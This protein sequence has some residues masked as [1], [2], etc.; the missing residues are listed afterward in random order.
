[1][2]VKEMLQKAQEEKYAIGAF[3]TINIEVTQAILAAADELRSPVII[4]VTEKTMDY[5]GGRNIYHTIKNLAEF[6]YPHVP[7][8]IHLDHGKSFEVVQRAVEVGIQSVMYDGS[9]KNYEDNL[10]VT[11]KVVDFCREKEVTVQAELGNVPYLGEVE[12]GNVDWDQYMTDPEQAR[13]FVEETGIDTL[14]VAI[15]NA[16][17]FVQERSEPDYA[18]LEMINK[19]I[20]KPLILHG[21]SDWDE[22]RVKKVVEL[23]IACFNVDTS[24]RLAFVNSLVGSLCNKGDNISFD[25]RK[26]LGDAR[27]QVKN[28]VK[29]KIKMF[30]SDGKA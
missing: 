20:G 16:H 27:E 3:N 4:Q 7:F 24:S 9:R 13:V 14:A 12:Q 5:A 18:R 21:A 15:G 28:A 1:M 26:H 17:G 23:G 25:V 19:H 2:N 11:K 30:G 22:E 10:A 8:G 6:Y 29:K